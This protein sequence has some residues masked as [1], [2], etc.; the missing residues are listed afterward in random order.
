MRLAYP[1]QLAVLV[2][3][4]CASLPDPLVVRVFGQDGF[5]VTNAVV[6]LMENPSSFALVPT[7]AR[8]L[9]AAVTAS[10]GDAVFRHK[11]CHA[12][13]RCYIS[14]LAKEHSRC[15]INER[16]GRLM[17][18]CLIQPAEG[19]TTNVIVLP[20]GFHPQTAQ[21]LGGKGADL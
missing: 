20:H 4:G 9:E 13:D 12:V 18:G 1:I 6:S 7:G 14:I 15:W 8:R 21:E 2:A 5:P 3:H 19:V 16:T 11:A 10:H 17:I